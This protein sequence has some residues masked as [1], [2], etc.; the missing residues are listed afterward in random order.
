MLRFFDSISISIQTLM[1]EEAKECPQKE[2]LDPKCDG[3]VCDERHHQVVFDD[4]TLRVIDVIVEPGE[5]ETFHTHE[6]CAVMYVDIPANI[7]LEIKDDKSITINNPEQRFAI[8]PEEGLH[9]VTNTDDK[10]FRAFRFEIKWDICALSQF[11]ILSEKICSVIKAKKPQLDELREKMLKEEQSK[12]ILATPKTLT[13]KYNAVLSNTE[14]TGAIPLL[15]TEQ[16][17]Q[18][19]KY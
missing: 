12:T 14:V 8:I 7:I 6:R 11:D 10:Q 19:L 4:A 18:S 3:A 17:K 2:L 16:P 9:R 5:V 15:T 13:L 1:K